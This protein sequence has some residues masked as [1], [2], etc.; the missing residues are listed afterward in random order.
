MKRR[1]WKTSASGA[2]L[3]IAGGLRVFAPKLG[4]T[5]EEIETFLELVCVIA[6][7]VLGL[8]ARDNN[9]SSEG[10]GAK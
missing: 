10:A 9:V 7:G 4:L 8:V 5:A 6:T 1:S 2:T 3:L